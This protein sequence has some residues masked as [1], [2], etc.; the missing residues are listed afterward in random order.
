MGL[1]RLKHLRRA[2][3][4]QCRRSSHRRERVGGGFGVGDGARREN[5]REVA[6]RLREVPH[7]P[8]AR[9]V[10]LLREEAEVVGQ[11]D[12]ALEQFFRLV[13]AAIA[14]ERVDEPEGARQ[15]LALVAGQAVVGLSGRVTRDEAVATELARNR[16]NRPRYAIVRSRQEAN[17]RDVQHA[18]VELARAV[19]LGEGATLGVISAFAYLSVDLV[20]NLL[21]A[22]ERRVELEA[23]CKPHRPVEHDPRHHLRVGVVTLRPARL[24]DP[25]VWVAPDRLDVLDDGSPA[26][27]QP[28]L[29]PAE[30]LRTE[31]HDGRNLA[32][33]V[34][35]KLLGGRVAY[36]D[37]RGALVA[38]KVLE[39]ELRQSP[40]TADPVHDLDRRRVA[41][42]D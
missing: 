10:V 16:V 22:L 12:Q 20:A 14:R 40:L 6:E 17:E 1:Y 24:P 31:E 41:G 25:V 4:R 3:G 42:A 2:S 38:G 26:R 15:E 19:V 33:Y 9:D 30:R 5:E 37:R 11:A 39:L 13:D 34:E 27:P 35:L 7:L 32:I 23:L 21:P 29:D 8:P 28:L 36:P 18:G